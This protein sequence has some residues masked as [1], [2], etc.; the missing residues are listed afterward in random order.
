MDRSFV[1]FDTIFLLR[2]DSL[3]SKSVF[4]TK[5]ARNSLALNASVANLLISVVVISLS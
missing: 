4:F 5:L 3:L 2:S 1:L